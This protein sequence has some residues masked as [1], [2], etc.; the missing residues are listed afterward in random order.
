VNTGD[1]SA[2]TGDKSAVS[3]ICPFVILALAYWLLML[4]SW[5]HHSARN[6]VFINKTTFLLG[7]GASWHYGYPTGEEL[8]K[9]VIDRARTSAGYFN[10]MDG[11][12]SYL[13]EYVEE[14]VK[15]K[16]HILMRTI[17]WTTAAKSCDDLVQR[18][19]RVNPPVIDYFLGHNEDLRSIEKLMI[20]WIILE[21]DAKYHTYRRNTNQGSNNNDDWCRFVLYKLLDGCVTSKDLLRNQVTFV[22]FNYDVSLEQAIY[23]GLSHTKLFDPKDINEFMG[24][25]RFLHIYG[26]MRDGPIFQMQNPQFFVQ[27][28]DHQMFRGDRTG[29]EMAK[30]MFDQVYAASKRIKTI[31]PHDKDDHDTI[32]DAAQQALEQAACVYILGY[33]FDRNNN[34]RLRL[35]DTLF[36]RTGK[37]VMFTN[38]EDRNQINKRASKVFFNT[39]D[40][41]L[42]NQPGIRGTP[43]SEFFVEKSTR[44]VYGAFSLDF[45][46]L[47]AQLL[48][49]TP[50]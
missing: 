24:N 14:Q 16:D 4:G 11:Q 13:P 10:Q 5:S 6:T 29:W 40:E 38:Y 42:S 43:G 36:Q 31:A 8:V 7:A 1:K 12:L 45:D 35:Y 20:A 33:G 30:I 15:T 49:S 23:A 34:M 50:I 21:S 22:T 39:L 28:A 48:P 2:N 18:L 25:G 27:M 3:T 41:L 9:R 47:E 44:N 46:D 26:S 32:I 19:E 37:S 17:A